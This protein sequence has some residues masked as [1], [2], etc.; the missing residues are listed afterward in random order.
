MT[1]TVPQFH[2]HLPPTPSSKLNVHLQ[3]RPMVYK[4]NLHELSS[5]ERTL[6]DV[7]DYHR[8]LRKSR[9][10]SWSVDWSKMRY[11][12]VGAKKLTFGK[13]YSKHVVRRRPFHVPSPSV[14][15]ST[16]ACQVTDS[17]SRYS[18]TESSQVPCQV[19]ST[20][21]VH[22]HTVSIPSRVIDPTSVYGLS[23]VPG[24]Q[25]LSPPTVE[26]G[27]MP[28][29]SAKILSPLS[30]DSGYET[31]EFSPSSSIVPSSTS[32]FVREIDQF[33]DS[34][35]IEVPSKETLDIIELD[36]TYET[37]SV[38]DMLDKTEEV[39][40]DT[41][42]LEENSAK[43]KEQVGMCEVEESIENIEEYVKKVT[44]TVSGK[45]TERDD[46]CVVGSADITIYDLNGRS[47]TV[48][49]VDPVHSC[50]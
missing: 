16:S 37:M 29:S 19:V 21:P 8:N 6:E 45:N 32:Q 14:L 18:S 10:D 28:P 2:P 5:N 39:S 46:E 30:V 33:L 11:W 7:L 36:N 22:S 15:S 12:A 44:N 9:G 48:M 25:E 34:F 49:Q 50:Q 40:Q 23:L 47:F 13:K 3:S 35:N 31:A 26:Y 17:L 1:R 41:E 27:Y 4:N 24:R 38:E 20:Q 42:F 43:S